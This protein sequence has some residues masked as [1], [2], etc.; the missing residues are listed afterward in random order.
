MLALR[1][2]ELIFTESACGLQR[3]NAQMVSGSDKGNEIFLK[4]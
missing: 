1:A 4:L 3:I 2:H